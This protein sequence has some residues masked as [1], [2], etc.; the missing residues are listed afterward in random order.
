[1]QVPC[2]AEVK[3]HTR[4]RPPNGRSTRP[5]VPFDLDLDLFLWFSPLTSS[6]D[7][8]LWISS[9]IFPSDFPVWFICFSPFGFPLISTRRKNWYKKRRFLY[10]NFLLVKGAAPAKSLYSELYEWVCTPNC[11][12][13]IRLLCNVLYGAFGAT[14][15]PFMDQTFGLRASQSVSLLILPF[16]F[17]L[18]SSPFDFPLLLFP[19]AFPICFLIT[20]PVFKSERLDWQEWLEPKKITPKSHPIT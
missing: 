1:M 7:F 14:L 8:P 20:L 10:Q 9:S 13:L 15:F 6:F 5:A 2:A 16:A 17:P 12:L 3:T 19:F 18:C 11:L 4:P